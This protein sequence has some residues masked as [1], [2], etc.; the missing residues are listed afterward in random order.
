MVDFLRDNPYGLDLE[1]L[2]EKTVNEISYSGSFRHLAMDDLRSEPSPIV[3][4]GRGR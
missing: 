3:D 2:I 4:D 1:D